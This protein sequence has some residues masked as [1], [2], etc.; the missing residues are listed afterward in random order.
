MSQR[1]PG[2]RQGVRRYTRYG[3]TAI[4]LGTRTLD[5]AFSIP[6][7]EPEDVDIGTCQSCG[8]YWDR[9]YYERC[10]APCGGYVG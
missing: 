3:Q 4:D 6:V 2:H 7:E 1:K 9:R 10:P 8:G 5:E